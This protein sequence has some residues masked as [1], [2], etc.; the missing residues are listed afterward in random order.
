MGHFSKTLQ[1]ANEKDLQIITKSRGRTE[2]FV[3][4]NYKNERNEGETCINI[5]S[6]KPPKRSRELAKF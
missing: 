2:E 3:I 6:I 1:R 4:L 5:C